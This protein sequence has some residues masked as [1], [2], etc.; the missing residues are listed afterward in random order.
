M[1][2]STTCYDCNTTTMH[3]L[4]TWLRGIAKDTSYCWLTNT[5]CDWLLC[6]VSYWQ[7]IQNIQKHQSIQI[8]GAA[9]VPGNNHNVMRRF[10]TRT[11]HDTDNARSTT[12]LHHI[13]IGQVQWLHYVVLPGSRVRDHM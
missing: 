2:L 7:S 6:I 12:W 10:R 5:D 4:Q 9:M 8:M 13:D 1:P 11:S 3:A